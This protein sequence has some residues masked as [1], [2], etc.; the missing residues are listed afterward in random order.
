[1]CDCNY[2]I[3]K[4][5]LYNGQFGAVLPHQN[6]PIPKPTGNNIKY[7]DSMIFYS[8]PGVSKV[9]PP[10]QSAAYNLQPVPGSEKLYKELFNPQNLS[11]ISNK[12]TELL[13]G[14]DKDGKDIVVSQENICGILTSVI[15]NYYAIDDQPGLN[16]LFQIPTRNGNLSKKDKCIIRTINIIV[17]YIRTETERI[18]CNKTLTIWNS[19]YGDF[20]EKGLRAH[21]PLKIQENNVN[22]PEF[23]MRY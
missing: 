14:L 6:K 16:T 18:D 7:Y 17:N 22:K 1:M 3:Y 9:N 20:N 10:N 11:I 5:S 4:Y 13:Q 23:H 21:P 8:G 19:V 15:N 12:I 2:N